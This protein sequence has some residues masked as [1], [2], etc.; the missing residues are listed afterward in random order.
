MD[1]WRWIDG[2]AVPDGDASQKLRW[3]ETSGGIPASSVADG[4]LRPITGEE[5]AD[6][7]NVTRG[8]PVWGEA[9]EQEA[10]LAGAEGLCGEV[11][12][13]LMGVVPADAGLV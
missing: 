10:S 1:R 7:G 2:E 9:E 4:A 3:E 5:A 12:M 6:L 11:K 13:F 8:S